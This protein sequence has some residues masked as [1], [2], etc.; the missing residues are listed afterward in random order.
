MGV[1]VRFVRLTDTEEA[2]AAM[3]KS[4]RAENCILKPRFER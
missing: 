2:N 3:L 1:F 4:R